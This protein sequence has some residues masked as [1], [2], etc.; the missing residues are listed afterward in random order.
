MA[1]TQGAEAKRM[2]ADMNGGMNCQWLDARTTKDN[3][4]CDGWCSPDTYDS[5]FKPITDGPAVYL[6]MLHKMET[7]NEVIIA[8]VGMSTTL[9]QRLRGHNILPELSRP[10]YWPMRWFKP[11]EKQKLRDIERQYIHKFDPPWNIV[12]RCRGVT[13][14]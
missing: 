10:G 1:K 3:L 13:L 12:G 4:V 2:V 14:Q 8:Y 9:R 7:F 6:F 11:I 5:F